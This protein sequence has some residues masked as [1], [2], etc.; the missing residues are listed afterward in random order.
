MSSLF[1]SHARDSLDKDSAV[2][3]QNENPYNL[4]SDIVSVIVG[5]DVVEQ[6]SL[7][8][9]SC[10]CCGLIYS[11]ALYYLHGRLPS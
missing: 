2:V 4:F 8:P 6:V 3:Q 7:T 9:Y 5:E 10:S 11:K 1:I